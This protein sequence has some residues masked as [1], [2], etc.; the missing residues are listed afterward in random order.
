MEAYFNLV[1]FCTTEVLVGIVI[2]HTPH[3]HTYMFIH[4]HSHIHTYMCTSSTLHSDI[5]ATS[6][7]KILHLPLSSPPPLQEGAAGKK[8]LASFHCDV[9]EYAGIPSTK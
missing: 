2:Q 3:A 5:P 1:G 4:T 8:V 9:S 6:Q 7:W